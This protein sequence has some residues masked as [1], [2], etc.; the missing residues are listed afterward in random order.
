MTLLL[1]GLPSGEWNQTPWNLG[2]I[3]EKQWLIHR[4]QWK[5]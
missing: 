1:N 2:I 4:K 3:D 5:S